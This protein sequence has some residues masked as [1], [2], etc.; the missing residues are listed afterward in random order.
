MDIYEDRQG[1]TL[2]L[3]IDGRLDAVTASRLEQTL[4]RVKQANTEGTVGGIVNISLDLSRLSYIS[5][6]GLRVIIMMLKWV[7]TRGGGLSVTR[8]S[9]VVK[10]VLSTSGLI[11]LFVH[12]EKYVII[13]NEAENSNE[14]NLTLAGEFGRKGMRELETT[15]DAAE[16]EGVNDITLALKEPLDKDKTFLKTLGSWQERY[17]RHNPPVNLIYV[18][19]G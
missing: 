17:E 11:D 3:S 2:S 8:I 19:A 15:L 13:R 16:R 9:P 1:D 14:L 12:D 18:R 7:K 10:D 6:A 4:E 5:S